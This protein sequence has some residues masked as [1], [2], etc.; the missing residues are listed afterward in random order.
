MKSGR[1][2]G[3][4][5]RTKRG[6][7]SSFVVRNLTAW[8]AKRVKV[9][10]A[11]GLSMS[12]PCIECIEYIDVASASRLRVSF[13]PLL[14]CFLFYFLIQD[15]S[16]LL[17]ADPRLIL[18]STKGCAS[19]ALVMLP[20][21]VISPTRKT[22]AMRECEFDLFNGWDLLWFHAGIILSIHLHL[23]LT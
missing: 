6:A 7:E 20:L 1:G 10:R 19:P 11:T 4:G 12:G 17:R 9:A 16:P 5:S 14:F 8:W 2:R 23:H 22:E 18:H 15:R 13:L 3:R 21:I